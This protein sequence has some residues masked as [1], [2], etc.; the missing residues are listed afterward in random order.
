MYACAACGALG[1]GPLCI[2]CRKRLVAGGTFDTQRGV[3]VSAGYRH[4]GAA[5][6]LVHALKY[7][8]ILPAARVLSAG[9]VEHVPETATAFVPVPRAGIRRWRHGV[10]PAGALAVAL[11]Q[12]TGIPVVPALRSAFWWPRHAG[13]GD[14]RRSMARFGARIAPRHGWV[15]VDDVATSGATL[16]AAARALGDAVAVALVATA[17]SRVR[18]SEGS[19]KRPRELGGGVANRWPS[20][21]VS[22][23][24]TLAR[25]FRDHP[26]G[27]SR[28]ATGP[29]ISRRIDG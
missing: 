6:Q 8:G 2:G 7:A 20:L 28:P 10:D 9:M 22:P 25:D 19:A 21:M 13:R 12:R 16:D 15:L 23:P 4:V 3:F 17:P 5:R 24:A 11:S 14:A 18:T 1:A 26:G 27:H 29:T